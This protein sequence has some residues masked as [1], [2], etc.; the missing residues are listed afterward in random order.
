MGP[1]FS[2]KKIM[3]CKL[4]EL[5]VSSWNCPQSPLFPSVMRHPRSHDASVWEQQPA[6]RLAQPRRQRE[7]I[8]FGQSQTSTLNLVSFSS[9]DSERTL[10]T[11]DLRIFQPRDNAKM[12]QEVS[13]CICIKCLVISES[14]LSSLDNL[15]IHFN[16]ACARVPSPASQAELHKA[17][18]T[19]ILN[20]NHHRCT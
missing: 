7:S 6:T 18:G 14:C 16:P 15:F 2:L 13:S 20:V 5:H 12:L 1:S 8:R 19:Y 17:K 9:S 4:M 10:V 11:C 3:K